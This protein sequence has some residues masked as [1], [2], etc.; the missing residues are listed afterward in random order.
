MNQGAVHYL[1]FLWHRIHAATG[2][3]NRLK[4]ERE[5]LFRDSNHSYTATTIKSIPI[6]LL[7]GLKLGRNECRM[8]NQHFTFLTSALSTNWGQTAKSVWV[9]QSELKQHN[10]LAHPSKF[11]HRTIQQRAIYR[12]CTTSRPGAKCCPRRPQLRPSTAAQAESACLISRVG[13]H[14]GQERSQQQMRPPIMYS[15]KNRGFKKKSVFCSL[16]RHINHLKLYY[17]GSVCDFF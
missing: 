10:S 4:R 14:S 6:T 8:K 5:N 12:G 9:C 1:P 2:Q 16:P 15:N 7:I 3:A 17:F 11:G 13:F